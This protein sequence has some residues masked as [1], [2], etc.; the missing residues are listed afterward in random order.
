MLPSQP[1]F[2]GITCLQQLGTELQKAARAGCEAGMSN[3]SQTGPSVRC[4]CCWWRN[5][6]EANFEAP[7]STASCDPQNG[8]HRALLQHP[9]QVRS[10]SNCAV[11]GHRSQ[12]WD[13]RGPFP[14]SWWLLRTSPAVNWHG[15]E[16]ACDV[17]LTQCA[18]G[19]TQT[20]RQGLW[21]FL[22]PSSCRKHYCALQIH[23][24]FL[25]FLVAILYQTLLNSVTLWI[26]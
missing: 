7:L 9:S 11:L 21:E 24:H 14:A 16:A 25:G 5:L 3:V 15:S 26:A 4:R 6:A 18:S 23:K 13:W 19:A 17:L 10:Q 22:G 2:C 20:S 12:C 1:Q 8:I